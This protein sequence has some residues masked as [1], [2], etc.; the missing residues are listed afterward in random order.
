MIVLSIMFDA[1]RQHMGL[2][3]QVEGIFFIVMQG[4]LTVADCLQYTHEWKN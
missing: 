3:I 4:Q 2:E 1:N